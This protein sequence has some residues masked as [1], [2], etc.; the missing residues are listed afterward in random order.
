MYVTYT[1]TCTCF[2]LAGEE[3]VVEDVEED[4]TD[5]DK[6][7]QGTTSDSKQQTDLRDEDDEWSAFQSTFQ[8]MMD[9]SEAELHREEM[10]RSGLH[11]LREELLISTITMLHHT[12]DT[13]PVEGQPAATEQLKAW[14]EKSDASFS[15]NEPVLVDKQSM[16]VP[17][18]RTASEETTKRFITSKNVYKL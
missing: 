18:T 5:G 9:S 15:E 8:S 4:R 13:P 14:R 12:P 1:C 6:T 3:I 16:N 10:E 7:L 11:Q 17:G 2:S